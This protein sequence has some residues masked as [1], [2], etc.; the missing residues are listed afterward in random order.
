[1]TR[2]T[3]VGSVKAAVGGV[4]PHFGRGREGPHLGDRRSGLGRV[5]A[6][7]KPLGHDRR[8]T[9][10]ATRPDRRSLRERSP[11]LV[12]G[13]FHC[14][15]IDTGAEGG[16]FKDLNPVDRRRAGEIELDGRLARCRV[17]RPHGVERA[18]VDRCHRRR[19]LARGLVAGSG[20]TASQAFAGERRLK[21]FAELAETLDVGR[22]DA[23]VSIDRDTESKELAFAD[24]FR[25]RA[26]RVA[27]GSSR[28]RSPIAAR[29]N[30]GGSKRPSPQRFRRWAAVERSVQR[31]PRVAART[32]AARAN[33]RSRHR[34]EPRQAARSASRAPR[35]GQRG[36]HP[37]RSR[38]RR[39]RRDRRR[40]RRSP[41][42]RPDHRYLDATAI[43]SP[44][45][46][47]TRR[48]RSSSRPPVGRGAPPPR[49]R[50]P[51]P[52]SSTDADR[53]PRA[54][55]T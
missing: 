36:P 35:V 3:D 30:R 52:C 23:A 39:R 9:E 53:H 42:R 25:T 55:P 18:V 31:R 15:P 6:E 37:I 26:V 29:T 47:P 14:E 49:G 43:P 44:T 34:S 50:G 11:A 45:L 24:G 40:H 12:D 21:E 4:D 1:V 7:P 2:A 48:A 27:R 32:A 28:A 5:H 22:R 46:S 13:G 19:A 20:R 54:N 16:R 8:A 41:V 51:A 33:P 17:G 38:A 10:D